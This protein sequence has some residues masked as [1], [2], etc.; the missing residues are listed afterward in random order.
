MAAVAFR[1]A[2]NWRR[3]AAIV[4][5]SP[6]KRCSVDNRRMRSSSIRF[7]STAPIQTLNL[8]SHAWATGG[9]GQ[10]GIEAFSG[11]SSM[12]AF[13]PAG[14]CS[15]RSFDRCPERSRI[16][17]D[18]LPVWKISRCWRSSSSRRDETRR[19][20]L[21]DPMVSWALVL[22]VTW[23]VVYAFISY[24]EYLGTASVR[25]KV[26]RSCRF[27]SCSC[28]IYPRRAPKCVHEFPAGD[29][30]ANGRPLMCGICCVGFV[31]T[32]SPESSTRLRRAMSRLAHRGPDGQ[33]V[34][35]GEGALP[36][37]DAPWQSCR[38]RGRRSADLQRGSEC[39]RRLQWRCS[40]NT[41]NV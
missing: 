16:C 28:S 19:D 1:L 9:S 23:T 12:I 24:P 15:R 20:S 21:D 40:T 10:E 29:V 26:S 2:G 5:A 4:G 11:V 37:D 8:L 35:E 18:Y 38:S 17:S 33:G 25:F 6:S 34:H 32:I 13:S 31:G 36:R 22:V 30:L 27:C 14:R 3:K 41:S 39:R 7:P